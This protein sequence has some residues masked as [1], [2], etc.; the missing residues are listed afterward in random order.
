[1]KMNFPEFGVNRKVVYNVEN[2][3]HVNFQPKIATRFRE[4]DKKPI[5]LLIKKIEIFFGKSGRVTFL[6]STAK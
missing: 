2:Y 3:L 5:K 1:M 6:L 4:N